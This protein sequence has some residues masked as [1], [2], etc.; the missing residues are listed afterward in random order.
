MSIFK[1]F[2]VCIFLTTNGQNE[3]V[4]PREAMVTCGTWV[5]LLSVSKEPK[6][7]ILQQ[8]KSISLVGVNVD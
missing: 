7:E 3:R 4:L 8:A 5:P 1:V 6:G 2:S